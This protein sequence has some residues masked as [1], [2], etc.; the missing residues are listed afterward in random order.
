MQMDAKFHQ[1]FITIIKI[2]QMHVPKNQ[3]RGFLR[4]EKHMRDAL[5]HRQGLG[6]T[7]CRYLPISSAICH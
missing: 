5:Q 6:S 3:G 2:H 1:T 7:I 4:K